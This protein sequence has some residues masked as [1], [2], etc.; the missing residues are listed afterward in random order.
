M[1][2]EI[3]GEVDYSLFHAFPRLQLAPKYDR[4]RRQLDQVVVHPHNYESVDIPNLYLGGYLA[5][6]L[7]LV[8]VGMHGSTYAI[9]ADILKTEVTSWCWS[10]S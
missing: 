3:G 5:A 7:D 2:V 8:V 6:G 9:A 10:H 1:I 4:Y